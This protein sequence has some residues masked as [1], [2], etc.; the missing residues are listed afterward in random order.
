MN[1][2]SIDWESVVSEW[3]ASGESQA[4]F[5]RSRKL[6][7]KRFYYWKSRLNDS[8]QS[9]FVAIGPGAACVEL[10]A[11]NGVRVCL[12]AEVSAERISEVAR[13]LG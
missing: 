6:D 11:P 7:L 9:S 3:R 4:S 5:C 2:S 10:I 8:E 1:Q 12:P 13:C